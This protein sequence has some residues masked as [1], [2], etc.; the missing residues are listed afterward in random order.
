MRQIWLKTKIITAVI[1]SLLLVGVPYSVQAKDQITWMKIHW[2]PLMVLENNQLKSGRAVLQ[3]RL[4]EKDMP[5][6]E[7][8]YENMNWARFRFDATQGRHVCNPM[9]IKT[10]NNKNVVELSI[11]FTITLPC[12]VVAK[13]STLA[14]IGNPESISVP[15]LLSIQGIRGVV[16][17]TR[18]YTAQVDAIIQKHIDGSNLTFRAIAAKSIIPMLLDNR[19]D[20]TIEY[21]YIADY[22]V[23]KAGGKMETIGMIRINGYP[24]IVYGRV[25]CPKNEWG[26]R[27]IQKVN[28]VLR[29][30][31]PTPYY[32]KLMEMSAYTEYDKRMIR[33]KYETHFL[34][35]D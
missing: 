14:R 16:Q 7:H 1:G 32:R 18:S 17:D 13:K 29:K 22:L 8:V 19:I 5:E 34:V 2:P 11:P 4:L 21:S 30:Q 9:A 20:Y 28:D 31:R 3:L 25:A 33:E 26:K 23:K 6:Y 12:V 24:P 35:D 27:V 10:E 15:D